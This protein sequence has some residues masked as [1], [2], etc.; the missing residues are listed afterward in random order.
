MTDG[1]TKIAAVAVV[2]IV[3]LAL[4]L[5]RG[6]KTVIQEG[7]LGNITVKEGDRYEY[8][9]PP[10]EF[11][12][13]DWGAIPDV[14]FD[15]GDLDSREWR[16]NWDWMQTTNLGC[17]CDTGFKRQVFIPPPPPQPQ[18]PTILYSYIQ[19]PAALQYESPNISNIVVNAMVNKFQWLN[20]YLVKLQDIPGTMQVGMQVDYIDKH[21]VRYN[22]V[23]F[24]SD[25]KRPGAPIYRSA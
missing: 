8:I 2:V 18:R 25:K 11:T 22:G 16:D 10:L 14:T 7:S 3:A 9:V 21:T 20:H 24:Y 1:E 5:K 13:F 23:N 17:A 19:P 4:F 15:L 12:V 6:G